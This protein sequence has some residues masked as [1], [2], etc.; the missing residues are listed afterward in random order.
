MV[1]QYVP[2]PEWASIRHTLKD[3]AQGSFVI[4]DT[5]NRK[6]AGILRYTIRH[7]PQAV[8]IDY[9]GVT[10]HYRRQGV[11]SVLI[12]ALHHQHPE[13]LIDLPPTISPDAANFRRFVLDFPG[14]KELER[15]GPGVA[16]SEAIELPSTDFD[17]LVAIYGIK[18]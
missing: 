5:R 6:V 2:V 11:G 18:S 7:D 3:H 14:V 17:W 4:R 13:Y 12:Q 8:L 15:E 10:G 1:K 9:I 16:K